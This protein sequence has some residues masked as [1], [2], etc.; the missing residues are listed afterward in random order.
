MSEAADEIMKDVMSRV[1]REMVA[2]VGEVAAR[3]KEKLSVPV[4]YLT[5]QGRAL[6]KRG[7]SGFPLPAIRSKRGEY[8]R[9]D[10]GLLRSTV[11]PIVKRTSANVIEGEVSTD[12]PYD[13]FLL[14]IERDFEA[15]TYA[16]WASKIDQ[17]F[18]TAVNT[19]V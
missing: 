10:T 9:K 13:R 14:R 7:K 12:T 11:T 3:L 16:E 6:Q 4:V 8:P 5:A 15:Y 17:R 2:F 1:E 19:P 18:T